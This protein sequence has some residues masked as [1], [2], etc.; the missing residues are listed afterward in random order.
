MEGGSDGPTGWRNF[1]KAL[2]IS[3]YFIFLNCLLL[4]TAYQLLNTR[5]ETPSLTLTD[6]TIGGKH[7]LILCFISVKTNSSLYSCFNIL[8]SHFLL[9]ELASILLQSCIGKL[10]IL[11]SH[12]PCTFGMVWFSGEIFQLGLFSIKKTITIL[13]PIG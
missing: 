10:L 1:S 5:N 3:H 11:Q 8:S 6:I 2:T 7:P 12:L 9:W 13:N 4:K